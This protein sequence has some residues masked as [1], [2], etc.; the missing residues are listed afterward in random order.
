MDDKQFQKLRDDLEKAD[1][2]M[3]RLLKLFKQQTG[4]NWVRPIRLTW[5]IWARSGGNND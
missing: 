1:Y 4:T 2:E 3:E 5:P